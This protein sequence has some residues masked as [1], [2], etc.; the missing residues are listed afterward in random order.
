VHKGDDMDINNNNK[1]QEMDPVYRSVSTVT[2]ARANASS[3]FQLFSF[4]VVCSGMISK[5][6]SFVARMPKN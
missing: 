3:V 5:G 1:H 6:F 4:L 2:A